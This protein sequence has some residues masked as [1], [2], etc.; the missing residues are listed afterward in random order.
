MQKGEGL[1]DRMLFEMKGERLCYCYA[2][3]PLARDS[4][5]PEVQPFLGIVEEHGKR[6]TAHKPVTGRLTGFISPSQA[7]Y[8]QHTAEPGS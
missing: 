1:W 5:W 3:S 6:V 2:P 8:L 7:K 4:H